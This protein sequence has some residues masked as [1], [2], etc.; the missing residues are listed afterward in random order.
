MLIPQSIEESEVLLRFIFKDNFKKKVI[1]FDRI[2]DQ[3]IFLD[4]RLTGISLQRLTYSS[5]KF[6]KNKG[7]SIDKKIFVG[8]II[9][10]KNDYLSAHKEFKDIRA[11]FESI[12]EFTPLD[13]NNN[14]LRDRSNIKINDEGNPSHSDIIYINPA[15]NVDEVKPNIALRIFSRLLYKKC[16]L[17]LDKNYDSEEVNFNPIESY[18]N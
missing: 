1:S 17:V 15:I 8:F 12:L 4:T 3:D 7:Q 6:C 2:I 14:Y 18:F 10:K 5:F 13:K 16:T 9:F 11:H